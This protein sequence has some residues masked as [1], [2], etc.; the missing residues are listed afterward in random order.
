MNTIE[1]YIKDQNTLND[2][3]ESSVSGLEKDI[4]FLRNQV[5]WNAMTMMSIANIL[6]MTGSST[7]KDLPSHAQNIINELKLLRQNVSGSVLTTTDLNSL[8]QLKAK[9]TTVATKLESLDVLTPNQ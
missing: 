7:M 2:K 6:E 9:T 4:S 1:Q 8:N 5:S 3:I